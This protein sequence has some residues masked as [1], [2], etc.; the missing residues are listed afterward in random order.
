MYTTTLGATPAYKDEP[1]YLDQGNIDNDI[2]RI[3]Q[4]FRDATD[5][6]INVTKRSLQLEDILLHIANHKKVTLLLGVGMSC[7]QGCFLAKRSFLLQLSSAVSSPAAFSG[8]DP[9]VA[10]KPTTV[11]DCSSK[12]SMFKRSSA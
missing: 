10:A 6:G 8:H 5:L 9:Y 12:K 2:V 4:M 3:N 11:S 1:F 7:E